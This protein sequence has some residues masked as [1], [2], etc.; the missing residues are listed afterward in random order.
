[1]AG[2]RL[3]YQVI[4]VLYHVTSIFFT[5]SV[6]FVSNSP[7][8]IPLDRYLCKHRVFHACIDIQYRKSTDVYLYDGTLMYI[9]NVFHPHKS[10]LIWRFGP[11]H[12]GDLGRWPALRA[13][14]AP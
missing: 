4:P 11:Q 5:Q 13:P 8:T 9:C 14:E 10:T 1:M 7:L 3:L 2:E 12:R 6:P